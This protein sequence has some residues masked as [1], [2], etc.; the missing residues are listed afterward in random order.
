MSSNELRFYLL[1]FAKRGLDVQN[2]ASGFFQLEDINGQLQNLYNENL[3]RPQGS[4]FVTTAE[5]EAELI[6]LAKELKKKGSDF[7]LPILPKCRWTCRQNQLVYLP[8]VW[9]KKFWKGRG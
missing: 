2:L 8:S 1:G 4:G 6:N 3:I 5:G 9:N 7:F